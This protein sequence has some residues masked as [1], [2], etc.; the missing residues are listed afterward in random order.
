MTLEELDSIGFPQESTVSLPDSEA[1]KVFIRDQ[2]SRR[3]RL[4]RAIDS[5]V[6]TLISKLAI[7]P[8]QATRIY[9]VYTIGANSRPSVKS[10][11]R[12]VDASIDI[13]LLEFADLSTLTTKISSAQLSALENVRR[14]NE[15]PVREFQC[16]A[17]VCRSVMEI[18]QYNINFGNL[19]NFD[20]HEKTLSLSN[21]SEMPLLYSIRKSGSFAS[22]DLTFPDGSTGVIRPYG[23]RTIRFIFKPSMA[24][25][26]QEPLIVENILSSDNKSIITVK[27]NIKKQAPFWLKMVSVVVF[28]I[29]LLCFL[30]FALCVLSSSAYF[31]FSFFLL[32][33]SA[34]LGLRNLR[35]WRQIQTSK[36]DHQEHFSKAA[37]FH[38]QRR[39]H[40]E[41]V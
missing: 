30:I 33:S 41:P 40:R 17:K 8:N 31:F 29:A 28:V 1:E 10:K 26:F 9:V 19:T 16:S 36:S 24:G 37:F 13:H 22:G 32:P 18:S 38:H 5:G 23:H 12:K 3:Q 34:S 39:H 20:R 2:I 6:L 4:Q 14:A 7:A 27:A 25:I 15:I 35:C 11:L 21:L